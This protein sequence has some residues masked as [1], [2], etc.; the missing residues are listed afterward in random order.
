MP[1]ARASS[2]LSGYDVTHAPALLIAAGRIQA[3]SMPA[4]PIFRPADM[5]R[6]PVITNYSTRLNAS[7]AVLS[8]PV[9]RIP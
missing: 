1:I 6:V 3:V 9:E 2:F 8:G 4:E 5:G 7:V